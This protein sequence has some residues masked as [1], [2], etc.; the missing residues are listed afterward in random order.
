LDLASLPADLGKT[1][2]V[3]NRLRSGVHIALTARCEPDSRLFPRLQHAHG[4]EPER[5]KQEQAPEAIRL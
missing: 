5:Q 1:G 4:P 3:G 2:G